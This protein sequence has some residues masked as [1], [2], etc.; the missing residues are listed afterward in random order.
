[1][2]QRSKAAGQIKAQTLTAIAGL[3]VAAKTLRL[4]SPTADQAAAAATDPCKAIWYFDKLS[5]HIR[6]LLS[7]GEEN[8]LN[9]ENQAEQL[10]LAYISTANG[11]K[12]IG[13]GILLAL[14][15]DRLAE[16]EASITKAMA[17]YKTA[18]NKLANLSATLTTLLRM[19]NRHLK[20]TATPT[21]GTAVATITGSAAVTCTYTGQTQQ[22]A[23]PLCQFPPEGEDKLG[24]DKIT[25]TDLTKLPYPTQKYTDELQ[26][27]IYAFWKGTVT[28][29]A[30]TAAGTPYWSNDS[31]TYNNG[32]IGG[33]NAIGAIIIPKP[34]APEI[35]P[36]SLF[37]S[38][39]SQECVQPTT[40]KGPY[41]DAK[42][43]VLHAVCQVRKTPIKIATSAMTAKLADFKT[44]VKHATYTM[45]AMK[46]QGLMPES[47]EETDKAKAEEFLKVVF[48][49]KD[50]AIGD[51]FIKPLSANKLSFS[52]KGKEQKEEANKIAKSNNAGN[53]IA[54]FSGQ[55]SKVEATKSIGEQAAVDPSKKSDSED[56]TGDKEERG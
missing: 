21:K 45:A 17:T 55:A 14:A 32:N 46:G 33:T 23:T 52:G 6:G 15:T 2:V 8:R 40:D 44:G 38:E 10:Q 48:G 19:Q 36:N 25:L 51:D 20:M 43:A 37:T 5:D 3:V 31:P 56:K 28:N 50:S 47:A 53:A 27:D 42:T 54:F 7:R 4:A 39:N 18:A 9:L 35:A 49:K 30:S 1:M 12:K 29:T 34:H 13:Y 26:A 11:H 22:A 16:Q 24:A 41:L